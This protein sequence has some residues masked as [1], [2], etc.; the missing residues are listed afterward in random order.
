MLTDAILTSLNRTGL[1]KKPVKTIIERAEKA[2]ADDLQ[3]N[4]RGYGKISVFLDDNLSEDSASKVCE[5]YPYCPYCEKHAFGETYEGY[6]GVYCSDR[7]R[8]RA[9]Q[10]LSEC[11]YCGDIYDG[12]NY[13]GWLEIVDQSFC[14]EECAWEGIRRFC[15]S[16]VAGRREFYNR[17]YDLEETI[18]ALKAADLR[19]PGPWYS[20]W[21]QF[22]RDVIQHGVPLG[23]EE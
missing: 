20:I 23:D 1:G 12:E 21:A 22:W 6:E 17:G 10:H 14:C 11:D 8:D 18:D 19:P 16:R 5:Q 3:L 9:E 7:C 15:S 2:I 4:Q 13:G